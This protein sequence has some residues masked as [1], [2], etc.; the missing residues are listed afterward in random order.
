MNRIEV[1]AF[2][3]VNFILDMTGFLSNG[4]HQVE[5]VMQAIELHD[6]VS[7]EW[8]DDPSAGGFEIVLEP[9]SA[10]LPA[11]ERNLAYKAAVRMKDAFRPNARGR[12]AIHVAKRI[13]VAAGLAGGSS[14]GAAVC[15]ALGR[16]WNVPMDDWMPVAAGLGSDVPFSAWAQNGKTAAFA[17]GT[18]T[19]LTAIDPVD[20][21]LVLLNPGYPVSTKEVYQAFDKSPKGIALAGS[22][23]T[24]S[25]CRQES[26]ADS[27]HSPS[28][29][30]F[31][32]NSKHSR[33]EQW[34]L[35]KDL[36]EKL[37]F[38]NNDL[39]PVTLAL[40]PQLQKV[41]DE[42]RALQPAPLAVQLS[43]SGP[44]VYAVYAPDTD[45]PE[46]QQAFR[47]LL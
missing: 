26:A 42:L 27:K 31:D 23:N 41:F 44:T 20:C 5:S 29:Q 12:L 28:A 16:I 32:A 40:R 35:A 15:T 17:T 10:E 3:K 14:N 30:S 9:G 8:D 34:M 1:A 46:G 33:C 25:L 21:R 4:F 45:T 37:Q 18:G 2:A 22:L 43:G 11:D 13:P 24:E 6:D 39:Q 7:V 19:E 47:T 36:K 38:L